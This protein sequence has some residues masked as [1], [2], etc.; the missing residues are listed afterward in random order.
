M[1]QLREHSSKLRIKMKTVLFILLMS[2]FFI[3]SVVPLQCYSCT[4]AQSNEICNQNSPV[5]CTGSQDRCMVSKVSATI[6][7][8]EVTTLT[9]GCIENSKCTGTVS[10]V[11][12]SAGTNCCDKDLCNVNGSVTFHE[13]KLMLTACASLIWL[14]LK[15]I[16]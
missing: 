11:I 6:L 16:N 10:V 13:N 7:G 12:V 5:N 8:K 15:L 14:I 9:K 1:T 4:N 2:Y 3:P